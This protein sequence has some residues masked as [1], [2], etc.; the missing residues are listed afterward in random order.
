MVIAFILYC[1]AEQSSWRCSPQKPTKMSR[2]I[3]DT[4]LYSGY[5]AFLFKMSEKWAM[6]G[7]K[8]DDISL[9]NLVTSAGQCLSSFLVVRGLGIGYLGQN[10]GNLSKCCLPGFGAHLLLGLCCHSSHRVQKVPALRSA[11]SRLKEKE[12]GHKIEK[13]Q[14]IEPTVYV[15][16]LLT[17][18]EGPESSM[19]RSCLSAEISGVASL[20]FSLAMPQNQVQSLTRRSRRSRRTDIFE[21]GCW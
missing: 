6:S 18:G 4:F 20:P 9:N 13:K 16:W 17:G 5:D 15:K 19:S 14:P 11:I 2:F 1:Q 8:N 7:H 12:W 3:N 10:F 21:D